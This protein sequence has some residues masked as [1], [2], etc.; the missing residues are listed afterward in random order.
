MQL[1][2]RFNEYTVKLEL[3]QFKFQVIFEN[4][5]FLNAIVT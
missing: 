2:I 1:R 3:I 4:T 5:L